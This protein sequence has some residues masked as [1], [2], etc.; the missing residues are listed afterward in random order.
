MASCVWFRGLLSSGVGGSR[1]GRG[2][3][4]GGKMPGKPGVSVGK[5]GGA[6]EKGR[7]PGCGLEGKYSPKPR[8][9]WLRPGGGL[10]LSIKG[11]GVRGRPGAKMPPGG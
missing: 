3:R 4:D 6:V 9:A 1:G 8:P 10:A 7:L 11:L 5:L 2:Y